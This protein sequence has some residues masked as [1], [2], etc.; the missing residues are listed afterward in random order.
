M[1]VLIVHA[2]A[3]VQMHIQALGAGQSWL[4]SGGFCSHCCTAYG[5][6]AGASPLLLALFLL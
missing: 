1:L 4:C 2:S 6:Y 5:T 3:V